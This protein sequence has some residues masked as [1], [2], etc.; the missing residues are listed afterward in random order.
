[1]GWLKD[2]REFLK[3]RIRKVTDWRQTTP[4]PSHLHAVL[5]EFRIAIHPKSGSSVQAAKTVQV[6]IQSVDTSDDDFYECP[7][8]EVLSR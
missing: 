1:M 6:A 2:N 3:A 5:D 4:H 7:R 8:Y